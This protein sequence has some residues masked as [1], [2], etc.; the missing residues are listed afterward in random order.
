MPAVRVKQT[1]GVQGQPGEGQGPSETAESR[2]HGCRVAKAAR[3]LDKQM[4]RTSDTVA[5]ARGSSVP[6]SRALATSN[7]TLAALHRER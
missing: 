5:S 3:Q 2:M 1:C 7:P 6:S 4:P